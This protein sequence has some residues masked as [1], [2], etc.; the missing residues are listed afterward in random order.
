[1]IVREWGIPEN[2]VKMKSR[3]TTAVV[4]AAF[5]LALSAPLA[6]GALV[7]S[8]YHGTQVLL[9]CQYS[10]VGSSGPSIKQAP[11]NTCVRNASLNPVAVF[12]YTETKPVTMCVE[13]ADDELPRQVR[14]DRRWCTTQVVPANQKAYFRLPVRR[15]VYVVEFLDR[16]DLAQHV[17]HVMAETSYTVTAPKHAR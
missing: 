15:G 4:I 12:S 2:D 1:M 6:F 8:N 16:T 10:P 3:G 13:L 5:V 11:K 17:L 9:A 7:T 14:L